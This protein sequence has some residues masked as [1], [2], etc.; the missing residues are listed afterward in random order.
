MLRGLGQVVLLDNPFVG[1]AVVIAA[2]LND[3]R[4][5]VFG[6]V[7]LAASTFFAHIMGLG[8]DYVR[9][10]LFGYNGYLTGDFTYSTGA[11]CLTSCYVG[12][13]L[14]LFQTG[15]DGDDWSALNLAS[16]SF[17]AIV[18]A[19]LSMGLG[20]VFSSCVAK[21]IPSFTLPFHFAVWTW[22]L[23]SQRSTVFINTLSDPKIVVPTDLSNQTSPNVDDEVALF[24]AFI[25]GIGQIFFFSRWESGG[26]RVH[27]AAS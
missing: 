22:L 13:A 5:A 15:W 24:D 17:A 18:S 12:T 26:P 9:S 16:V 4:L 20:N 19:V 23:S 1:I 10:G 27:F 3:E 7:G 25:V 21:P 14:G 8:D 2:L 6:L 11:Y